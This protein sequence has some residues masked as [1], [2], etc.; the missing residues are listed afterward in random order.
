MAEKEKL[1]K[2]RTT[3]HFTLEIDAEDGTPPQKWK[4]CFDY[5]SIA[6][7]EEATGLDLKKLEDWKDISSGKQF[8]VIVHG[9]LRRYNPEVTLDQVLDVLNPEAQ[10]LLHATVFDLLYPGLQE[11][12]I[13]MQAE[14]ATGATASPNVETAPQ[15]S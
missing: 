4:L 7:I 9:G 10:E 6:A 13:K 15:K 2:M 14:K 11:A 12:W 5:R 3:P 8:P 1:V